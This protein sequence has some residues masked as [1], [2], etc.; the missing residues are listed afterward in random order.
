LRHYVAELNDDLEWDS[1]FERTG[2]QLLEAV[3][4]AKTEIVDGR[5]EIMDHDR[6]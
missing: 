1:L 2:P 6:L 4:R 5:A 3:R